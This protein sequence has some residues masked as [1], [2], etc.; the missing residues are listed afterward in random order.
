MGIKLL[1][2]LIIKIGKIYAKI[3]YDTLLILKLNKILSGF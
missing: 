3:I 1:N 2:I